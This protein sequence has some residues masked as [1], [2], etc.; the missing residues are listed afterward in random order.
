M[1]SSA[2]V[3]VVFDCDGVLADT[4]PV[5]AATWTTLLGKYGYRPTPQELESAVGISFGDTHTTYARRMADLPTAA[6]LQPEADAIYLEL[7]PA[8][9]HPF[10]DGTELARTLHDRK[11]PLALASSST[12]RR[13]DPTLRLLELQTPFSNTVAGDEVTRPKPDPEAYLRATQLLGTPPWQC[14]ATEDSPTGLAAATAAGLRTV[15]VQR[16][17]RLLDPGSAELILDDLRA[18][19]THLP[20]CLG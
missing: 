19:S 7:L 4:E 10:P 16:P 18:I 15:G 2:I 5:I 13:L 1:S 14:L 6:E 20:T 8:L 17:G 11:M 9:L 3:G 12:R